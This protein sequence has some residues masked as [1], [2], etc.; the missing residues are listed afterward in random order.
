MLNMPDEKLVHISLNKLYY[1]KGI[2]AGTQSNTLS[3]YDYQDCMGYCTSLINLFKGM[4]G[5][6]DEEEGD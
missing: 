3:F 4:L 5:E 6:F 1:L 2:L